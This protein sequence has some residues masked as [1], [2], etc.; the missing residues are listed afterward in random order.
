MSNERPKIDVGIPLYNPGP[1]FAKA[2]ASLR[3]QTRPPDTVIVLDDCSSVDVNAFFEGFPLKLDLA[4]NVRNRGICWNFFD[5]VKKSNADYFVFLAQDDSWEP[6][7]LEKLAD[8]L[9][10]DEAACVAVPG[11]LQLRDGK[12]IDSYIPQVEAGA[13]L[14]EATFLSDFFSG[15]RINNAVYY[16]LWRR[17]DLARI[18]A[19]IEA[20][21]FECNEKLPVM[22]GY[23]SGEMV[24]VPE[25]LFLKSH[26]RRSGEIVLGGKASAAAYW[27]ELGD[28]R[29]RQEQILV[30]FPAISEQRRAQLIS[31]LKALNRKKLVRKLV[32]DRLLRAAS[33][34]K[35]ALIPERG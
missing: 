27:R 2:L 8:A 14:T 30:S 23:I 3:A 13:R 7:F 34:V 29:R 21:D 22:L 33:K 32:L 26:E 16:G 20:A 15:K 1:G 35:R 12:V 24:G 6:D 4:R 19:S 31:S 9:S 17:R 10:K 5:L 11:V 28:Q 25:P 18:G